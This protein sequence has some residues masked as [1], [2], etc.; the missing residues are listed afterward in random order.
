MFGY[1]YAMAP[2][3]LGCLPTG[4]R[5]CTLS[6]VKHMRGVEQE[7]SR[8]IEPPRRACSSFPLFPTAITRGPS[9]GMGPQKGIR[10]SSVFLSAACLGHQKV[11]CIVVGNIRCNH[12]CNIS[13]SVA[14]GGMVSSSLMSCRYR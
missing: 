12:D 5:F 11:P 14:V 10:L 3:F 4:A 2:A 1:L 7:A 9:D 8:T 13:L 6:P